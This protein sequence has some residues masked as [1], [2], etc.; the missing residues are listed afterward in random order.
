MSH[1]KPRHND[2]EQNAPGRTPTIRKGEQGMG[3]ADLAA[4][5]S[6]DLRELGVNERSNE[7]VGEQATRQDELD[8]AGELE[9]R[10][11]GTNVAAD[12]DADPQTGEQPQ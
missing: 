3:A 8:Q 9:P 11:G 7:L 5:K 2:R 1:T 4:K 6:G 12:G 10:E